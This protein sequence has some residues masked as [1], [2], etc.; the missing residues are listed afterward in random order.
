MSTRT[1]SPQSNLLSLSMNLSVYLINMS[2]EPF[3]ISVDTISWP[4][5]LKH[6]L[7]DV[8]K[9]YEKIHPNPKFTNIRIGSRKRMR[10][11]GCS[12]FFA[13]AKKSVWARTSS[14][15]FRFIGY[16]QKGSYRKLYFIFDKWY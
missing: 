13:K 8:V 6:V 3:S 1:V 15:C 14:S 4:A 12:S 10:F 7:Q 16:L 5:F 9:I 11:L 2:F